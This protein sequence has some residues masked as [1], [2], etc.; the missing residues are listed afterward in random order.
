[1]I[2]QRHICSFSVNGTHLLGVLYPARLGVRSRSPLAPS[3]GGMLS[4]LPYDVVLHVLDFLCDE[5]ND[6]SV[7][8]LLYN[9][10]ST[11]AF[12]NQVA[13]PRL[14]DK[15][16]LRDAVR[17]SMLVNTL[18]RNPVM[19]RPIKCVSYTGQYG[20]GDPAALDAL[21]KLVP[22]VDS[23][24]LGATL[25]DDVYKDSSKTLSYSLSKRKLRSLKF[26]FSKS[27]RLFPIDAFLT[28]CTTLRHLHLQQLKFV[29]VVDS[30]FPL[31]QLESLTLEAMALT[32]SDVVYFLGHSS[33]TTLKRV[34][35]LGCELSEWQWSERLLGPYL[36]S[37]AVLVQCGNVVK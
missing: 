28:T 21:L 16:V 23:I 5:G 19:S 27:S 13:T 2:K 31:Y 3:V 12:L 33:R 35:L 36:S 17:C 32:P 30:D 4:Q 1:M 26:G 34:R 22:N 25:F 15:P 29:T 18:K 14:Y 7:Q 24:E 10:C 11:C 9:L 20:P 8:G 6:L 37:E